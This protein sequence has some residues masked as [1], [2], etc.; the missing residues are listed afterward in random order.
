VRVNDFQLA[1]SQRGLRRDDCHSAL[2]SLAR[3]KWLTLEASM[4]VLTD[5]GWLAVTTGEGVRVISSRRVGRSGT[6][7]M[8]IGLF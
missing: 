8:P 3:R 6:R 7:R 4:L 1:M 2:A 5:A